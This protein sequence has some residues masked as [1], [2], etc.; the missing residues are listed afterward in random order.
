MN[1]LE[2]LPAKEEFQLFPVKLNIDDVQ[3]YVD[4]GWKFRP[5]SILTT[6]KEDWTEWY[7]IREFVQNSL[8]ETGSFDLVFEDEENISYII[9]QGQGIDIMDMFLGQ[10]KGVT[11]EE[12]HCLRGIFGEGMKLALLP[13]LNN[14][15][16]VI[17]RTVKM[18]YFFCY[19][20]EVS[21]RKGAFNYIGIFTRPN[22]I[23]Q[24]TAVAIN[25]I[26]CLQ[27]IKFFAPTIAKTDPDKVL[28]TVT[29]G[30]GEYDG[31]KV[32]Q[33]FDIPGMIFVRD[34]FVQ[35]T[36]SLF[37]YNFWF[38]SSRDA[39]GS[40]RNQL[41]NIWVARRE[42]AILIEGSNEENNFLKELIR[43]LQ[44]PT[45]WI[46]GGPHSSAPLKTQESLEWR[47]LDGIRQ[48]LGGEAAV[49][50]YFEIFASVGRDFSWSEDIAEQKALEHSGIKDLRGILPSFR[51]L[52]V[53]HQLIRDPKDIMKAA[54]LTDET[55]IFTVEDILS[56]VWEDDPEHGLSDKDYLAEYFVKIDTEAK[57]LLKMLGLSETKLHFYIGEYKDEER[58]AGFHSSKTNEIFIRVKNIKDFDDFLRVFIHEA[59][60]AHCHRK[61]RYSWEQK[62]GM[63]KDL[64]Q[65]FEYSLEQ[66]ASL[67]VNETIYGKGGCDVEGISSAIND[68]WPYHELLDGIIQ[69]KLQIVNNPKGLIRPKHTSDKDKRRIDETFT[70]IAKNCYTTAQNIKVVLN[71]YDSNSTRYDP[72]TNWAR[73]SKRAGREWITAVEIANSDKPIIEKLG[74]DIPPGLQVLSDDTIQHWINWVNGENSIGSSDVPSILLYRGENLEDFDTCLQFFREHPDPQ[75]KKRNFAALENMINPW[76][77]YRDLEYPERNKEARRG[78]FAKADLY[79]RILP[80]VLSVMEQD[81]N[82][83]SC[84][85]HTG[86]WHWTS[87]KE[88]II[89]ETTVAAT[90]VGWLDVLRLAERMPSTD[91]RRYTADAYGAIGNLSGEAR[92]P[93][94]ASVKFIVNNSLLAML[95]VETDANVVTT[96]ISN[97]NK[98]LGLR[99]TNFLPKAGY[100]QPA[101]V[102]SVKILLDHYD[103][104]LKIATDEES[105][106]YDSKERIL[107]LL[108]WAKS[109]ES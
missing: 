43:R 11:E 26:N 18:D 40:D 92:S 90:K 109:T 14:G 39:L 45:F 27:Y 15:N 1:V 41:K 22:N 108:G 94:G 8:D 98:L 101:H 102:A 3:S 88:K 12:I 24:G 37:G 77:L 42:I 60:H 52:L 28:L 50:I 72:K 93:G 103:H 73:G 107:R 7:A 97:I 76:A 82:L 23:T 75:V 61:D 57:C 19:I 78:T 95:K 105:P 44:L 79:E 48:Y 9:D 83:Y 106:W 100:L 56:Y 33:V 25:E 58:V 86:Q 30:R 49:A 46:E 84:L 85:D 6:Y 66:V 2:N 89:E 34:I 99:S 38:D 21:P 80:E 69:H 51:E 29:G 62:E 70:R 5:T 17:I 10:Q 54:E 67:V 31:C 36:T 59:A 4:R 20:E 13:L 71:G 74:I 87:L 53:K 81:K 63:C 91:N 47:C 65:E 55:I 68:I 104:L 35:Y 96:I 64:T 32:R 16:Q